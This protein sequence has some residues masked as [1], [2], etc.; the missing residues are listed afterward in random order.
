MSFY[1]RAAKL[2]LAVLAS[3]LCLACSVFEGQDNEFPDAGP[4][5]PDSLYAGI[6]Q[7][8]PF[9]EF[10]LPTGEFRSPYT[11]AVLAVRRS[12]VA[13]ILRA[14]QSGRLRL[15]LNLAGAG[16][17]Y[18][19]PDGTFNLALW[20]SRIDLYRDVDFAPYVTEGL[21]LAHFLIDEPGAA[22][23]WGEQPVSRADIEEMARYSKSIWPTLPTTV[24]APP[25]WLL[26][27]DTTYQDLDIAWAQWAGPL[28]GAGTGLTPEQFRDKNVALAK[29][30][31]LGLV[32]GMNY[33]NGGDGSS[34]MPG[35]SSNPPWWQMST[36]E[37]V[38]VGT[39]LVQAPYS[40]AFLSWHYAPEYVSRPDVRAAL[41]S[42]AAVAA[43]R[44]GTSCLRH[45]STSALAGE[46]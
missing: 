32:F 6:G 9:G 33:L 29:H 15:V 35:T 22:A 10:D 13:S 43:T 24:R 26:A 5:G 3:I 39:L 20:K 27:G 30:L 18:T 2:G 38:S 36:A 19:N 46:G 21:V 37:L 28:H 40:C 4:N 23:T 41:D 31:G 11:G 16:R 42:I 25:G 17:H 7:G 8:I 34:G 1:S 14:A 12:N 44:G 45:D